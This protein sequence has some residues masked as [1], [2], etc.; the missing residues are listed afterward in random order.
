MVC[1]PGRAPT[2]SQLVHFQRANVA[3][4]RA[5]D[6]CIL[7]RSLDITDIPSSDD[8]KISIVS[9]FQTA[10]ATCD[11]MNDIESYEDATSDSQWG[12]QHVKKP[13][14]HILIRKMKKQGYTLSN[15]G[16]VWKDGICVEHPECD[17]RVA[18]IIG[19]ASETYQ[20]WYESYHQ[21]QKIEG[22]GWSCFRV[23]TFSFLSDCC[24]TMRSI[25]E[26]LKQAGIKST[27]ENIGTDSVVP[28]V[29][30]PEAWGNPS[31]RIK[32][33]EL[34][35]SSSLDNSI[36]ASNDRVDHTNNQEILESAV[37]DDLSK[38]GTL[39]LKCLRTTRSSKMKQ[40]VAVKDAVETEVESL[41]SFD[42][43]S[44]DGNEVVDLSFLRGR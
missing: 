34:V 32:N 27:A 10:A 6:Q 2:Q 22:V 11:G 33:V 5:R 28:V 20:D 37:S 8:V 25:F 13:L 38:N 15:M 42:S 1:S 29:T 16:V 30:E 14:R 41:V 21:Q 31:H 17:D 35:T 24:G 43:N 18:L 9:F 12:I 4:S 36:A 44:N 23:D 7:V 19:D 40:M 39:N 26:F 3:M